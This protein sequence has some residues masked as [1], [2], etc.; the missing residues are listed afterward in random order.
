MGI[1]TVSPSMPTGISGASASTTTSSAVSA[2]RPWPRAPRSSVAVPN[3]NDQAPEESSVMVQ[4]HAEDRQPPAPRDATPSRPA[5]GKAVTAARDR[6]AGSLAQGFVTQLKAI[7]FTDQVM[8]FGA[9]LLVSLLPFLILLSAFASHRLGDDIAL[10]LGLN[11]RASGIV[12][13]LLTSAPATL[14]FATATSLLFVAAGSLAVA[15]SLQ[16]IYEKVFHQDHLGLRGAYRLLIWISVLCLVVA[17]ESLVSKPVRGAAD[18]VGLVELV[19]FA[20]WTPFFWWTMHFLLAGVVALTREL[21]YQWGGRGV[22]VNALAPSFFPSATTGWLADPEQ[23]AWISANTPLG[24]PPRPGELDGPLL[25][26]ASDASSYV[27]G[28]TLYV[29]GGWTCR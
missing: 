20:I 23:V 26:L 5:V 6:Y 2:V 16:Q 12:A 10:R 3:F 18:G 28:Q 29:D 22:R 4:P 25:F 8:L 1:I 19:T 11:Q 17:F 9:G 27:T 7:D 14:N 24:R 13:H 21:A 15:S